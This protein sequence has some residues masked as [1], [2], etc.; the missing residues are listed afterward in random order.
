MK[1]N[2]FWPSPLDQ[3]FICKSEMWITNFLQFLG[4]FLSLSTYFRA[5]LIPWKVSVVDPQ[6][7]SLKIRLLSCN[8]IFNDSLSSF[9]CSF[10]VKDHFSLWFSIFKP[11]FRKFAKHMQCFDFSFRL[12]TTLFKAKNLETVLKEIKDVLI[13][14]NQNYFRNILKG[15]ISL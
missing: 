13:S 1:P 5:C 9:T 6:L 15:N 14:K 12:C 10:E 4:R 7:K 2:V 3:F 8:V 11:N